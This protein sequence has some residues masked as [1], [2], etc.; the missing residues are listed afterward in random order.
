MSKQQV[1]NL[2]QLSEEELDLLE[3]DYMKIHKEH[4]EKIFKAKR[5]EDWYVKGLT[6]WKMKRMGQTVGL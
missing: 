2:L 5:Y 4:I 6:E 1:M 3:Y